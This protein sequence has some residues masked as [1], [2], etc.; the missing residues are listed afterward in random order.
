M[1]AAYENTQHDRGSQFYDLNSKSVS[2][3]TSK[4]HGDIKTNENRQKNSSLSERIA[5]AKV[6]VDQLNNFHSSGGRNRDTTKSRD[7]PIR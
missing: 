7:K 4:I 3:T 2:Q 1:L 5:T 6:R